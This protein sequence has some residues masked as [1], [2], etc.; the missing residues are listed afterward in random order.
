M[1]PEPRAPERLPVA[2]SRAARWRGPATL[3]LVTAVCAGSLGAALG[4]VAA[5]VA[6]AAVVLLAAC[7]HHPILATYLYLGTLPIIAGID[8]G[9]A[10]PLA[11]PN[12]ALL[13]LLLAGAALGGYLRLARG[14]AVPWRPH[15]VDVPLGL[16]LVL[17]TVWP[18]AAQLLRQRDVGVDEAV[19]VLPVAKLVVLF[20][21][22][23]LTVTRQEQVLRC[24]RL[25]IWPAAALAVVAILQTL[26]FGPVITA[27][28]VV[29]GL[30]ES[31]EGPSMRGSS[32]LGSSIATGDYILIA[33]T[34][35]VCCAARG[36]LR[37]WERWGTGLVLAAGA[38]AAGQFSTWISAIVVAALLVWRYPWLMRSARRFWP[39][40]LV[41]L[42]AGAPALI[43]RLASFGEGFGVPRSWLGRWDNLVNLYWPQFDPPSVLLGVH[44]DPVL[45]AP[46]TWR[47]VVYLESGYLQ[48][49]WI[50]G[51]PLLLAFLWLAVTV[52]R[53][54]AIAS[55]NSTAAGACASALLIA[56]CFVLVLS[57]I[58][59]HLT[60]R[61]AGDLLFLL[62]GILTASHTSRRRT[63][64]TAG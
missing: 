44:P 43:N 27:L 11:R 57:V 18:I 61:G 55:H 63:H 34:L 9:E 47:D 50:G 10:I 8:R 5:V 15:P 39:L 2:S 40:G 51:L 1:S 6:V 16:F 14:D 19:A 17:S 59:A 38:L 56:W 31:A 48:F 26:Q 22:V 21:L 29:W 58:D 12:E 62:L 60:L 20:L 13:V 64:D 30:E 53:G 45:R 35:I 46:E 24:I 49:V 32:T 52:L 3:G 42:A 28:T 25:V 23:R 41:A 54:A 37:R 36:L 33:L 4:P 7:A